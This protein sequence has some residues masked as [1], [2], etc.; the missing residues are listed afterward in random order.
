[1]K[2][3]DVNKQIAA[4]LDALISIRQKLQ[5]ICD[6]LDSEFDK[7]GDDKIYKPLNAVQGCID[8]IREAEKELYS[9]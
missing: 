3:R 6:N 2:L 5:V 7:T 1:M 9:I 8:V 4:Q